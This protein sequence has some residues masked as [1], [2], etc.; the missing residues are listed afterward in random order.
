MVRPGASSAGRHLA[1]GPTDSPLLL[2]SLDGLVILGRADAASPVAALAF[3]PSGVLL[4]PGRD[5]ILRTRA[6]RA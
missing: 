2:W 6:T 3:D 4:S 1:T 5:A